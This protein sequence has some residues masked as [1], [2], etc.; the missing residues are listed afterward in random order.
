VSQDT[1]Q[2]APG[3][4]QTAGEVRAGLASSKSKADAQQADAGR[5][6]REHGLAVVSGHADVGN[7]VPD[8]GRQA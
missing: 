8:R 3:L 5:F 6:I 4:E 7:G 1:T 2:L